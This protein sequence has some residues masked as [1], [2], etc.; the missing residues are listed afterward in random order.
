VQIGIIKVGKILRNDNIAVEIQPLLISMEKGGDETAVVGGLGLVVAQMERL[1]ECDNGLCHIVKFDTKKVI[2]H[3]QQI[4]FM[5]PGKPLNEYVNS[6]RAR[7]MGAHGAQSDRQIGGVAIVD[8]TKNGDGIH[9]FFLR[10][11][12][13]PSVYPRIAVE[14]TYIPFLHPAVPVLG[15]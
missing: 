3:G 10:V 5:L 8:G 1:S 6:K 4:I 12:S 15:A 2:L 9:G 7:G 11:F 13:L 14:T